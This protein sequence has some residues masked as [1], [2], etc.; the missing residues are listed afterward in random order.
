M[1]ELSIP[2]LI[3]ETKSLLGTVRQALIRVGGNLHFL[4]KNGTYE[5][6]GAYVEE[7]FGLSQ[8]TTSK[9]LNSY[10][11]WVVKMGFT[12]EE[13]EGIDHE[14]LYGYIP[15]LEGKTK[16]QALAEVTAWSRKDIKEEKTEKTPCFHPLIQRMCTECWSVVPE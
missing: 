16:E 11:N 2:T 9:L 13:L 15:L 6:F 7:E 8:T 14:K 1:N 12:V 4:R 5:K 10:E 3:E